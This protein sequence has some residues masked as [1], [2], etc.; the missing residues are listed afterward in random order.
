[1]FLSAMLYI[2]PVMGSDDVPL[3]GYS[4]EA[5]DDIMYSAAILNV[6][7]MPSISG[8]I[9][10]QLDFG[11]EVY[12]SDRC[13][14][15]GWFR[16]RFGDGEDA[17]VSDEYLEGFSADVRSIGICQ[18]DGDVADIWTLRVDEK[19]SALPEEILDA[20]VEEGWKMYVTDK[21]LDQNFYGGRFGAVQG[22]TSID[23]YEIFIEDRENAVEGSPVHEMGHFVDWYL[24][25]GG[26]LTDTEEFQ[27]I[28]KEEMD[29]FVD[30]LDVK[31]Y[32]DQ[33]ELFAE[34]IFAFFG[35]PEAFRS[36]APKLYGFVRECLDSF[37]EKPGTADREN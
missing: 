36:C 8:N 15:T 6:R 29:C 37:P 10:G 21:D 18:K 22:T 19:L 17:F 23:S 26:F 1:M 20:F 11:Q 2:T 35:Q 5:V 13:S 25:D 14:E 30:G 9:I 7:D 34:G 31:C 28:Y 12:V 32:M 27:E 33:K 3:G 16:I 24:G 4:F